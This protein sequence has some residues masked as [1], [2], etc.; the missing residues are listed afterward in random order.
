MGFTQI[1]EKS[2]LFKTTVVNENTKNIRLTEV[3]P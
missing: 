3:K 2:E 1:S